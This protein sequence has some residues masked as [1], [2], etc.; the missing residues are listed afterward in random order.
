MAQFYCTLQGTVHVCIKNSAAQKINVQV[1]SA[2]HRVNVVFVTVIR[3]FAEV[4]LQPAD[5]DEDRR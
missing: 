4:I 3:L 1:P 2:L 5:G